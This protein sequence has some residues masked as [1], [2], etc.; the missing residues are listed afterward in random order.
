M[1]PA[2]QQIAKTL[3]NKGYMSAKPGKSLADPQ[4]IIDMI[5]GKTVL[6]LR[7]GYYGTINGKTLRGRTVAAVK[8]AIDKPAID[9]PAINEPAKK[10]GRKR[11]G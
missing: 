11:V 6:A 1:V 3:H 10:K 8:P 5:H 7:P 4:T 2:A 9:I